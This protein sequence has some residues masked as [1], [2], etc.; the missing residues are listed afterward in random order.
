MAAAAMAVLAAVGVPHTAA[1]PANTGDGARAHRRNLHSLDDL[2]SSLITQ[3]PPDDEKAAAATMEP[4]PAPT[5]PPTHR[6]VDPDTN[7]KI[8]GLLDGILGA[9][10]DEPADD[11]DSSPGTTGSYDGSYDE[12]QDNAGSYDDP[13][14]GEDQQPDNA[15]GEEDEQDGGV[16]DESYG[17][18]MSYGESGTMSIQS[19]HS[20]RKAQKAAAAKKEEQKQAQ[21]DKP[22]MGDMLMQL[23]NSEIIGVS[24]GIPS[25]SVMATE[26]ASGE[27][28]TDTV[29]VPVHSANALG[30]N[31]H[32]RE[33]TK[34]KVQSVEVE[35]AAPTAVHHTSNHTSNHTHT[36]ATSAQAPAEAAQEADKGGARGG[37]KAFVSALLADGPK[38]A[39]NMVGGANSGADGAESGD[40]SGTTV[41]AMSV[42]DYS[43]VGA[44]PSVTAQ[45]AQAGDSGKGGIKMFVQR[46][47]QGQFGKQED[48]AQ[49]VDPVDDPA[50]ETVQEEGFMSN[51][52]DMVGSI[53]Q[54]VT[55]EAATNEESES[56]GADKVTAMHHEE[57]AAPTEDASD[58]W[59]S[60]P[61][62]HLLGG[63]MTPAPAADVPGNGL[64]PLPPY[65]G[66]SVQSQSV[67]Q[68]TAMHHEEEAA[69][70]EDA[71][72]GWGKKPVGHL[73]GGLMSPAPEAEVVTPTPSMEA[74]SAEE[75]TQADVNT[76][77]SL[78]DLF[79]S[80]GSHSPTADWRD[81]SKGGGTP[82]VGSRSPTMDFSGWSVHD[83][84][85]GM[86]RMAVDGGE[87]GKAKAESGGKLAG[88]LGTVAP[89]LDWEQL[90]LQTTTAPTAD[91]SDWLTKQDAEENQNRDAEEAYEDEMDD[92][93]VM[94]TQSVGNF[95]LDHENVREED[96]TPAATPAPTFAPPVQRKAGTRIQALI[97]A[98]SASKSP[99]AS[100]PSPPSRASRA[101]ERAQRVG[102]TTT[103]RQDAVQGF[104][105][106]QQEKEGVRSQGFI[107]G[108]LGS[109][110]DSRGLPVVLGGLLVVAAVA[111][112]AAKRRGALGPLGAERAE[113]EG[114]RRRL[115]VDNNT[116]GPFGR[117]KYAG[118]GALAVDEEALEEGYDGADALEVVVEDAEEGVSSSSD[119]EVDVMTPE[120][121][122]PL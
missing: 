79:S 34:M 120:E 72:G 97:Q 53:R 121:F 63:L 22:K 96:A 86:S 58:G 10:G 21:A 23:A 26:S 74:E 47:A 45:N 25:V 105:E 57:E 2:L 35:E 91:W 33:P 107:H 108:I 110:V 49:A 103:V 73:L 11:R 111:V 43:P 68:M 8:H 9:T 84:V 81:A 119:L 37:M 100:P 87:K 31:E 30:V 93:S 101:A 50:V 39:N 118:Y 95:G 106:D 13:Y 85:D 18:L 82:G 89:T 36:N 40:A 69:P 28:A 117:G 55:N 42:D 6:K 71:S 51:T 12:S 77:A 59:G 56:Q 15:G 90:S 122:Q 24:S 19:V 16:E 98:V 41:V 113:D 109:S 32:D 92:M 46:V 61:V 115:L 80:M 48:S 17:E 66:D 38:L 76:Q 20:T 1:L 5:P 65:P 70:T 94:R 102:S 3:S 7:Q 60:K 78:A 99:T 54:S 88:L 75:T 4:T 52:G 116:Q 44:D 14:G 112:L 29:G 27:D 104:Q 67:D 64:P 114:E 62:G 83:D